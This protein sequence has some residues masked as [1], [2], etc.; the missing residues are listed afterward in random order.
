MPELT[1]ITP[2]YKTARF[3]PECINSV[4]L[5][6]AGFNYVH[7][8][9]D[10][11]SEDHKGIPH[12]TMRNL[13]VTRSESNHGLGP[14]LV[15]LIS[16]VETEWCVWLNADD[17]LLPGFA[18]LIDVANVRQDISGVFG[19]TV[20]VDE[21]QKVM[22]LLSRYPP[23]PKTILDA[24]NYGATSALLFRR[25]AISNLPALSK[26]ELLT[27]AFLL[28]SLLESGR[29]VL[30]HPAHAAA[31]LR[32]HGALSTHARRPSE[33]PDFPL[34]SSDFPQLFPRGNYSQARALLKPSHR[35]AK[36]RYFCYIREALFKASSRQ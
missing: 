27:D 17:K 10:D 25:D 29:P 21:D 14:T 1:V 2:T 6:L 8:I 15:S 12:T 35:W 36:L 4:S 22:R 11:G 30:T 34:L 5:S 16:S 7:H 9:H 33:T 24:A 28:L 19:A 32:R 18:A 13:K 23:T 31:M 26:Y 20:F 3:L